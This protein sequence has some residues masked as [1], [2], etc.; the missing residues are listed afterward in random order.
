MAELRR[1]MHRSWKPRGD[2]GYWQFDRPDYD[3]QYL[4]PERFNGTF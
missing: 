1:K 4:L 2:S 3:T